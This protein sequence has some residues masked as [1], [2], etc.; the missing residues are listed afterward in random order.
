M[1]QTNAESNRAADEAPELDQVLT[2]QV[3]SAEYGV[4]ISRVHEIRGYSPAT[5]IPTS[6]S[7]VKGVINLRGTILPLVDLRIRFGQR[8]PEYGR[9][10]V[11]IVLRVESAGRSRIVGVIVDAVSDVHDVPPSAFEARTEVDSSTAG[12]FVKG[13]VTLG[14]TVLVVLD[15]DALLSVKELGALEES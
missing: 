1:M 5:R 10:T 4:D 13:L 3:G 12:S 7:H 9:R 11:V 15:V 6:P 14:E 8:H 2:F